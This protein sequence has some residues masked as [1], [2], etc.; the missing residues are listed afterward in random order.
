MQCA[1][2]PLGPDSSKTLFK[3]GPTCMQETRTKSEE[4]IKAT[5]IKLDMDGD[6]FSST[7]RG[8]M[9]PSIWP[10]GNFYISSDC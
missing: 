5:V 2:P 8:V 3:E 6:I 7:P 1:V 10:T 4:T 9:V